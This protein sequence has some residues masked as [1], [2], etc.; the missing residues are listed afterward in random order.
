MQ[1][2]R[3]EHLNAELYQ[4]NIEHLGRANGYKPKTMHTRVGEITFAVP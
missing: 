1:A 4:H 2:E 3:S